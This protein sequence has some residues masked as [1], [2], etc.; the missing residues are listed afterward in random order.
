[1]TPRSV[2]N[3]QADADG[4]AEGNRMTNFLEQLVAEWYE[5]KA[6]SC[7]ETY[8]WVLDERVGTRAGLPSK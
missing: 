7:D 8:V 2:P 5:F 4:L 3:V 1:M 6:T